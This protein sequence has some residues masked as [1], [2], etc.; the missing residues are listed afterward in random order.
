MPIISWAP[1]F[2]ERNARPARQKEIGAV[3]HASAQR[4]PHA[5][6]ER[7][8]ESNQQSVDRCDV[9]AA[10]AWCLA[11][12]LRRDR[13]GLFGKGVH[14]LEAFGVGMHA[15]AAPLRAEP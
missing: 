6:D 14:D 2:A 8:I 3:M 13:D 11:V 7:D 5:E 9:H 10:P 12:L 4:E 15:V 1:R